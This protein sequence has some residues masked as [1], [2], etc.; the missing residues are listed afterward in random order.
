MAALVEG[1][2][3]PPMLQPPPV[4]SPVA[5][6][7]LG[8]LC[9]GPELH[10]LCCKPPAPVAWPGA[11][12]C[13][14]SRELHVHG[15]PGQVGRVSDFEVGPALHRVFGSEGLRV[16][17]GRADAA[18]ARRLSCGGLN[19]L[20]LVAHAGRVVKCT[21]P[22]SA[23]LSEAREA[24][25]LRRDA[26]ALASDVH[27]VFPLAAFLCREPPTQQRGAG[28]PCE[29]AVFEHLEGCRSLGDLLRMFERSHPVGALRTLA[30]CTQHRNGQACEHV[31][32]LRSLV[33]RQAARLNWRFQALHGRRHGDFK[34]DN[35]LLDRRGVP[36]LADFLSPFCRSCDREEFLGSTDSAHPAV[37]EMRGAFGCAWQSEAPRADALARA[38]G[39][40]VAPEEALR[41]ARLLEALEQL[42]AARQSQSIFGPVPSLLSN[43]GMLVPGMA[44]APPGARP[45][46]WSAE[47]AVLATRSEAPTEGGS[48]G[49][50]SR[51]ASGSSG[52]SGGGRGGRGD[53]RASYAL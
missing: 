33:A 50:S 23:C 46:P 39:C 48:S 8:P 37:M 41:N 14:A 44:P 45:P 17:F 7:S 1:C 22:R 42:S 11:G 31:A 27:A 15:D 29:V 21:R 2:R 52:S 6:R 32:P 3:V 36:R 53:Q 49:S 25:R 5:S 16:L 18:G 13:P 40:L 4:C 38:P 10:C 24:A 51:S 34:A 47:P 12:T 9:A 43:I 28:P 30:P 20:F 35:V 26:P 19:H